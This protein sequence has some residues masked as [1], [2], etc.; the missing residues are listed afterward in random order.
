VEKDAQ[1][2][3]TAWRRARLLNGISRGK[4]PKV[5]V[6]DLFYDTL[7]CKM[8]IVDLLTFQTRVSKLA[9]N[10]KINHD[11]IKYATADLL[12][13]AAAVEKDKTSRKLNFFDA[14]TRSEQ[15]SPTRSR[16]SKLSYNSFHRGC[17]LLAAQLRSSPSWVSRSRERP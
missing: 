11:S 10:S 14:R 2:C 8:K 7:S 3:A 16:Y 17:C 5:R 1:E 12:Q 13:T 15:K 4:T 6:N 9:K